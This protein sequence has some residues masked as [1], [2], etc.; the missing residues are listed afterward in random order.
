MLDSSRL[1]RTLKYLIIVLLFLFAVHLL[2]RPSYREKYTEILRSFKDE[3][4]LFVDDFLENE[5]D[6][7]FDGRELAKLCRSKKW[8]P[9]NRAVILSC[10]PMPGGI[11]E[12]KNGHLHCI[13]FA[14]EIGAQLVLPRITRRSPADISNLYGEQQAK[15]QPLDYMFQSQHLLTAL[16]THCPQMKVHASLDDLYDRPSLL[17]PLPVSLN[18]LTDQF[19]NIDNELVPV[20]P[21]PATAR[22]KFDEVY[23]RELP[24]EG[25]RYPVRVELQTTPFVWPA[26]ADGDEFRRD[27][28]RLLRVRED[29]RM[30]AAS[31]LYNLAKRFGVP[32]D[33]RR[34]IGHHEGGGSGS[35][36]GK[37]GRNGTDT[38][39]GTGTMFLGVHLRTEKDVWYRELGFPDYEA[40]TFYFFN[41]LESLAGDGLGGG[42]V[43]YL[44]TGLLPGDDDVRKFRA[45][46]AELGATVVT[47]RDVL[48][49]G[50]VAM[51]NNHLT[52]DQRALVD[53][54]IMLRVGFMMGVVE[55]SFAWNLA[56]RRGN[57]Y[58]GGGG[59]GV[60]G[61][62]PEYG[63]YIGFSE[64]KPWDFNTSLDPEMVVMWRDRYT[65]LYG[66][67]SRAVAMFN[68]IW[69]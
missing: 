39:T 56:M 57:V 35:G 67:A 22:R 68:G 25:R 12:V 48:G 42:R 40:Q 14:I 61:V 53:Y 19:A 7:R 66:R 8:H 24:L 45:R 31:G 46:A 4:R 23:D 1:F 10:Q 17:K 44:A 28:G 18:M 65:T 41:H 33:P 3:K 2:N 54:E 27:F 9:E 55:S 26:A 38:S 50:E 59:G 64:E 47:K 34:G 20:I 15:G 16:N 62:G 51:L 58:G 6:G 43:V 21:D 32:H 30:L 37:H 5:I 60:G 11:G 13:R 69:P 52:W 29:V 36:S 49:P 63:G